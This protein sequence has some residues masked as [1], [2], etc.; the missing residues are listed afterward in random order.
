ME[1]WLV[2]YDGDCGFCKWLLAGI[3]TCD[4]R[5]RLQ[6]LALQTDSTAELLRD[7]APRAATRLVA[8]DWSHA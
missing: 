1:R 3:L 2:L 5:Q 4:R 6:P 7:L 8:S